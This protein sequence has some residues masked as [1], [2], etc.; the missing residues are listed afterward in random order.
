MTLSE[1]KTAEPKFWQRLLRAA[2]YYTGAIDG[3]LGPKSEEAAQR[4]DADAR[5]GKAAYGT[6]DD[7]SERNIETLLPATQRL[8]RRWLLNAQMKA[9]AAGVEVKI[10]CGTRTY[11][12]QTALYNQK[13]RVTKAKAGQSWHNFGLAWD[14]G[15]FRGKEYL[16][17]SAAYSACGAVARDITGLRWGG[18]W[19]TFKDE[20]HIQ[21]QKFASTAEARTAFER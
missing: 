9:K 2:G 12:E 16:G 13:P 18:D 10:I 4:W 17:D 21:W 8:A 20:P 15:I 19:A 6:F 1:I 5:S 11:G 7:R 3:I 14:M